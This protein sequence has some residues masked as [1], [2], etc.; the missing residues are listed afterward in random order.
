MMEQ[1]THRA[2][3][4][5]PG[6]AA[7]CLEVCSYRPDQC[8]LGSA[9]ISLVSVSFPVKKKKDLEDTCDSL[10]FEE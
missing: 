10:T 3:L 6:G 8:D 9:T 2:A 4:V 1:R 5:G 7:G